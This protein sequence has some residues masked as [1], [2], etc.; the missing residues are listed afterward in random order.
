VTASDRIHSHRLTRLETCLAM[1]D[2]ALT[3]LAP[4]SD[5][6]TVSTRTANRLDREDEA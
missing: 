5:D 6:Q 3:H 2:E 1:L 4:A